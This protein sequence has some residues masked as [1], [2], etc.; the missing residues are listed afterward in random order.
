MWKRQKRGAGDRRGQEQLAQGQ[1]QIGRWPGERVNV[2]RDSTSLASRVDLA[3]I[4]GSQIQ[5]FDR[6]C[7][8]KRAS[9]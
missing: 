8:P 7:R 2:C 6:G 4:K 1:G 3:W 9:G 5:G